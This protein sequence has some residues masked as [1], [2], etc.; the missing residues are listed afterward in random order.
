MYAYRGGSTG[1][2]SPLSCWRSFRGSGVPAGSDHAGGRVENPNLFDSL[3]TY[4]W[5]FTFAASFLLYLIFMWNDMSRI[6]KFATPRAG[7]MHA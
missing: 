2:L 4:A 5:F 7:D 1:A 3:Y 6:H